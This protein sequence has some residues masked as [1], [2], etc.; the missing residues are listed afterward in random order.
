M[1]DVQEQLY[2]PL[3]LVRQ[4]GLDQLAGLVNDL[5]IFHLLERELFVLDQVFNYNDSVLIQVAVIVLVE[6]GYY[7]EDTFLLVTRGCGVTCYWHAA[8][9]LKDTDVLL[10]DNAKD[11]LAIERLEVLLTKKMG[12]QRDQSFS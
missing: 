6:V 12:C 1:V 5:K 9:D 4:H 3:F 8:D 2:A 10:K 7:L 11:P